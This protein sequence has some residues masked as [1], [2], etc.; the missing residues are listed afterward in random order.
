M[1]SYWIRRALN[2]TTG[3]LIKRLC[4]YKREAPCEDEDRNWSDVSKSQGMPSNQ[5]KQSR[6][7]K[8]IFS[9]RAL[10][11]QIAN[12]LISDFGLQNHEIIHFCFKSHSLWY[13]DNHVATKTSTVG[14]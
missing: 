7:I 9:L 5:Q 11:N 14:L 10:R 6:S 1:R 2:P 4:E 12:T 3:V 8:N 13:R